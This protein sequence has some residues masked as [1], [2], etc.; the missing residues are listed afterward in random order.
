MSPVAITLV[1]NGNQCLVAR[2]PQFPKGMYSA[3]AGFCEPGK[4]NINQELRRLFG[5]PTMHFSKFIFPCNRGSKICHES[6]VSR[7][8]RVTHGIFSSFVRDCE[9][10]QKFSGIGTHLM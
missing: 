5:V 7:D 2:Q 1:T 6:H 9:G 3:L 4:L 10:Q 8:S